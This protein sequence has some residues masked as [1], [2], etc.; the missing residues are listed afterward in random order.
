MP[1]KRNGT[2]TNR[3]KPQGKTRR[4]RTDPPET[5]EKREIETNRRQPRIQGPREE[6]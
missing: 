6:T 1:K 2:R 5:M 4:L 3:D